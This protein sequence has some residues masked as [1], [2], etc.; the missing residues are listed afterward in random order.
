M[1]SA[2]TNSGITLEE[3][4]RKGPLKVTVCLVT[5]W[6]FLFNIVFT[7]VLFD[8]KAWA[9]RQPLELS[10]AS[11]L[12]SDGPSRL[13]VSVIRSSSSVKELRVDTF[14]LPEYL[15]TIRDSWTSTLSHVPPSAGDMKGEYVS[16]QKVVIHIQD[17]HCNYAAQHKIAETIVQNT[18]EKNQSI[19]TLDSMQ[20]T[21]S[22]D[23]A[24]GT[25]YLSVMESNLDVLKQALN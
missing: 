18:A 12:G 17:A 14:R 4:F 5:L 1:E 21:T 23:V 10:R 9:A 3:R 25:T 6:S 15:G 7:D 20:S 8:A 22:T 13:P 19:L 16:Q 2:R 24:N 11:S